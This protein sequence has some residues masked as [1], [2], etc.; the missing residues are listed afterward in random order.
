[1]VVRLGWLGINPCN[2]FIIVSL[3]WNFKYVLL[4]DSL[5][6]STRVQKTTRF[7]LAAEGE[8]SVK[9]VHA[10]FGRVVRS[11]RKV[12]V[13][14][15][16]FGASLLPLRPPTVAATV[17]TGSQ[18]KEKLEPAPSVVKISS[19]GLRKPFDASSG[20]TAGRNNGASS[21]FVREAVK[22]YR[23]HRVIL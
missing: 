15:T 17:T 6:S 23:A 13:G 22:G 16:L 1:M 14:F 4:V 5:V 12:A 19:V 7:Y 11:V 9:H 2:F 18:R 10:V 3:V 21:N 8:K 20:R